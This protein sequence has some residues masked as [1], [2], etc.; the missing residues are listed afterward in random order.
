MGSTS[1]HG[2]LAA[3]PVAEFLQAVQG[4]LAT[5]EET[6]GAEELEPGLERALAILQENPELRAQFE[7]RVINLIDSPEEGVVEIVSFLMHVLR[8]EAV[9]E[10]VEERIG[11]PR[12][13][14]SNIR[15]YEAMLDAFS[16]S[17]RDRDLFARFSGA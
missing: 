16:D 4:V 13:N 6:C 17:W 1:R 14:V 9:R 15:L 8:W 7:S 10:A 11:N 12:G 2:A 5:A 3:D